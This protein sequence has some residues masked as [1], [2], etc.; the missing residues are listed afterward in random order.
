[1]PMTGFFCQD[2]YLAKTAKLTDEE[3]GRLFRALMVYHATGD[4]PFLDLRESIAF[5]FIREDIDRTEK[6]YK[7]KCEKNRE[8]RLVGIANERQRTSTNVNEREQYKEKE[9]EE[10]KDNDK[11]ESTERKPQRFSPPTTEE[12]DAYCRE[13]G[14]SVDARRFVDYYTAN[15][16]KVGRNPMKDW[17]ATVRTWEKTDNQRASP[18]PVAT[19]PAQQYGQRDNTGATA[20]AFEEMRR[21]I[22]ESRGE[23]A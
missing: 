16:W 21:M 19:V 1:M 12:V 8:N 2:E 23:T 5:D 15:G 6:K 11:R 22:R 17:K 9:K 10:Y 3:L 7:D 14:N 13:R 4:V 18:A 20:Q